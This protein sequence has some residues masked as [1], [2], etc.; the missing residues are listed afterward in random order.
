MTLKKQ[1]GIIV[2]FA[3]IV[4]CIGFFYLL[5]FKPKPNP[6]S[7]KGVSITK[8]QKVK[9]PEDYTIVIV[10][11]SMTEALGN[12]TE[13]KQYL[14]DYYKKSFEILN[15]GF[16]STNVLSLV[17]RIAKETEHGRK[18][19][20]ISKIDY[21]LIL[22]ESF[23]ENPP[24]ELPLEQGLKRQNEELDKAIATLQSSHPRGK[25]VFVA[26]ISPNKTIFAKNQVDLTSDVRAK[27][28]QERVAYI[29]NHIDYANSHN[30]PVINIF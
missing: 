17:D 7:A 8:E 6:P 3:I 25:V 26:T 14:S 30:I 24:S 10:G 16:G 29:Q 13:L 9:Y 21:D 18:F 19:M 5:T 15:Y 20:P 28:V 11:D 27:W 22:I 23:G 2:C 12:S 1:L 4:L